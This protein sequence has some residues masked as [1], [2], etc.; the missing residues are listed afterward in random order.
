MQ[1]KVVEAPVHRTLEPP[2]TYVSGAAMLAGAAL[3]ATTL[4]AQTGTVTDLDVLNYALTLENLE[5]NFYTEGLRQFSSSDFAR[6]AFSANLGNPNG[7]FGDS[8]TG[9]VYGYLLLIRS[10]EQ[11]HV[12]TLM[13]TI[14]SLGGRP[15]PACTYKFPYNNVD[16]FLAIG[17]VLEDTGVSAYAGAAK[18]IKEPR[19]LTA[20]ATIATVEAR[21]ASY[22]R[23]ITGDNPFPN[24]FDP[25]KTM[26]EI[27][28][29]AGPFIVSCPA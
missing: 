10:H 12:R 1:Q 20:A 21:H 26:Q 11:T 9:D 18:L 5:A 16:E 17:K 24:A 22:L 4:N 19:L 13:R 8:V 3:I 6:G 28:A 27:L 7:V 29:A 25:A 14:Q 23:L 15:K 2:A